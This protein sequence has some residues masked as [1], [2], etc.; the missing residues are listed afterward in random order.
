MNATA[1]ARQFHFR[2]SSEEYASIEAGNEEDASVDAGNEESASTEDGNKEDTTIE[3]DNIENAT[4]KE[5]IYKGKKSSDA[6]QVL[7][8]EDDTGKKIKSYSL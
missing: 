2:Y 3:K 4:I 1:D 8:G 7:D 6:E 5:D